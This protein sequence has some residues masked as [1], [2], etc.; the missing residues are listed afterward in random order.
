MTCP[1]CS[2]PLP[3]L[4]DLL[5]C[6]FCGRKLVR[7]YGRRRRGNGQGTARKRGST[8]TGYAGDAS[9]SLEGSFPY[10]HSDEGLNLYDGDTGV[11]LLLP[12]SRSDAWLQA[13]YA[14]QGEEDIREIKA[15]PFAVN[16]EPGRIYTYTLD[17]RE[18]VTVTVSVAGLTEVGPDSVFEV[19]VYPF[20]PATPPGQDYTE[21]NGDFIVR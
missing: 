1:K 16:W 18:S 5:F 8:W 3:E 4:E 20:T 2:R 17:I 12:Q 19:G 6:P 15:G 11:L 10:T 9:Y 14:V 21:G 7:E 13:L